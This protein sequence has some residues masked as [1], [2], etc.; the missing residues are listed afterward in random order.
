MQVVMVLVTAFL[1]GHSILQYCM[2]LCVDPSTFGDTAS[3]ASEGAHDLWQL[4]Q[5]ENAAIFQNFL[6]GHSVET[7]TAMPGLTTAAPVEGTDLHKSIAP[8]VR[9]RRGHM[10]SIFQQVALQE[11]DTGLLTS[12]EVLRARVKGSKLDS[13]ARIRSMINMLELDPK[14]RNPVDMALLVQQ[15]TAGEHFVQ[16]LVWSCSGA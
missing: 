13:D 15:G 12:L 11:I 5:N 2:Y 8:N 9:Q 7:N 3:V 16:D 4:P 14:Q 10:P 1:A 6:A